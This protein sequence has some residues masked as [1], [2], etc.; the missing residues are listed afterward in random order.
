MINHPLFNVDDD[1]PERAK[2]NIHYI[3]IRE[4]KPG[5]KTETLTNQ[6]EPE[7]LLTPGDV[8]MAVG[9]EGSFELVGRGPKHQVV[10]RQYITVKA[11]AGWQPQPGAMPQQPQVQQGQ[12]T[13]GSTPLMQANGLLIPSNMDPSVAMI[14]SMMTMQQ[15]QT[16]QQ[17]IAQQQSAERQ[18]Q[19]S[20]QASQNMIQMMLGMQQNTT[21]LIGSALTSLAPLLM[22]SRAPG[23]SNNAENGFL[24]GIEIMAAVK[25]GI[26]GAAKGPTTDWG[27]VSGNIMAGI[28]A[29]A[30]VAK[31]TAGAQA[32]PPVVPPGIPPL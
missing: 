27:A 23:D 20:A 15:T 6:W 2:K 24:K 11:P 9:H 1:D 25:E 12:P 8:F 29:L 10:D 26:D 16:Q 21:Q 5:N 28:K 7:Q 32:A 17:M 22:S 19:L 30:E 13:V 14:V 18:Q 3:N 4:F 31:Q